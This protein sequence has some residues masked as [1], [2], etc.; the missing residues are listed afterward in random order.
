MLRGFI[1][2]TIALAATTL[3]TTV[4]AGSAAQERA[5]AHE[6]TTA[7]HRA[8]SEA[9][10]A[11]GAPGI[12]TVRTRQ[13]F[14][15]VAVTWDGRAPDRITARK[16][17]D[18]RWSRWHELTPLSVSGH[19]GTGRSGSGGASGAWWTG[20]SSEIRIRASRA[21]EHVTDELELVAITPGTEPVRSEPEGRT[22]RP[23]VVTRAEWGADE[24]L[25]RWP[26]EYSATTRAAIVHHT[27]ETNDYTCA[28]SAEVVRGL[29]HYH[30]VELGWGD[31]GYHALV[32]KCGTIFEGRTD[33]LRRHVVGGHT[34][35]FNGQTFGVALIGDFQ[36]AA[37]TWSALRS[38]GRIAGWKLGTVGRDPLGETTLI[39]GGGQGNKYP[40]GT[41][42]T[43][44]R[45]FSHRDVGDTACP[46]DNVHA[47]M[48]TIRRE[49]VPA[50]T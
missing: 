50:A 8:L 43:L 3:V 34:K 13:P 36:T 18:G 32:D 49:S 39:S 15:M 46:G 16:R 4:S 26:P 6:E 24:S 37:P 12:R 22:A 31:I 1:A 9:P 2:G 5:P 28:G 20:P 47:R 21:G 35:G 19:G 38:T 44:P 27:V 25:M 33:G 30:A 45:I 29:Y 40:E 48:D 10:A 41:A 14:S 7:V 42:V 23:P 11:R 17:Q